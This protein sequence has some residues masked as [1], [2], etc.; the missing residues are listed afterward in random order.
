[1]QGTID[2]GAYW[3]FAGTNTIGSTTTLANSGTLGVNGGTFTNAGRITGGKLIID[4]ATFINSG[5][6]GV[7]TT[8]A[9]TGDVLNNTSTGTIKAAGRVVVATGSA[10]TV[11][12]L[13]TIQGTGAT[14]YGIVLN[15]GGTITNG[16]TGATSAVLYGLRDGVIA[17]NTS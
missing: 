12:N 9:G 8:L 6:L 10:A 2:A 5:Y 1:T 4:P 16:A 3:V 17:Y 11:N 15:A 14:G 13:G 7:A